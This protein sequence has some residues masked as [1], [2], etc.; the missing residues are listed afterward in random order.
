MALA[1]SGTVSLSGAMQFGGNALSVPSQVTNVSPA[2]SETHVDYLPTISWQN[3][4]GAL[5]YQVFFD[6]SNPPVTSVQNSAATSYEPAALAFST[7]YYLKINSINNSGTTTGSVYSFTTEPSYAVDGYSS[8]NVGGSDGDTLTT[9]KLDTGTE[10]SLGTWSFS[11]TTAGAFLTGNIYKIAT[12]GTTDFTLI[13]AANSNVGTVFTATGAGAGTGTATV[14][15]AFVS[16]SPTALYSPFT[17]GVTIYTGASATTAIKFQM[18]KWA[19]YATL[20]LTSAVAEMTVGYWFKT[21]ALAASN[22]AIEDTFQVV[23]QAGGFASVNMRFT[24]G[25]QTLRMHTEEGVGSDINISPNTTYWITLDLSEHGVALATDT[26]KVYNTTGT[27][28][29]TSTNDVSAGTVGDWTKLFVGRSDTHTGN[30]EPADT[31]FLN[32]SQLGINTSTLVYP[33]GP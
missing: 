31:Q 26:L 25:S 16:T 18:N 7:V 14:P 1:L 22:P 20:T 3:G 11:T 9:G 12:A 28:I 30:N 6:T 13:G 33:L 5:T 21:G 10:V 29:G 24:G 32:Y 19:N 17:N 23:N 8:L 15:Y 2:N 4:G 27:L